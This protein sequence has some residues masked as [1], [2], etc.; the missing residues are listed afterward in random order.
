MNVI[1]VKINGIEY[2]LRGDER[3]EY[4]HR[5]ASYV[6]KKLKNIMDNNS[7]L[8]TGSAA[9]LAAMNSADDMFKCQVA[10]EELEKKLDEF[11]K[12][13]KGLQEQQET[14]KQQ[15]LELE[16][17]NAGLKEKLKQNVSQDYIQKKEQELEQTKEELAITQET[18]AQS[19]EEQKRLVMENKELKFQLQSAKYKV[20]DLENRLIDNQIDLA[21]AKKASKKP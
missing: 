15:I 9:M 14:L 5:V 10:Y 2:N 17:Q 16:Q 7:K 12:R 20:I 1:T 3:E 13:E 11:T 6:D 21:K 19:L 4:L 18:A 8:S